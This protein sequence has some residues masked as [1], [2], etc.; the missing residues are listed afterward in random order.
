MASTKPA[1]GMRD[2]LP[3]EVRKRDFVIGVSL[4]KQKETPLAE[5]FNDYSNVLRATARFADYLAI[6]VSSPNTPNL[7]EFGQ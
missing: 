3:E 6:N 7:R 4:G 2:F 1:R 5:A